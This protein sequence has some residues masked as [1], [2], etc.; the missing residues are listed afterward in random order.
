MLVETI[1]NDIKQSMRDRDEAKTTTLRGLM[2]A[3][4]YEVLNKGQKKDEASD[5][6][7]VTVVSRE[8]KK[9]KEA[10][11]L[12][13]KGERQELADK[14]KAEIDI[15]SLYLPQQLSEDE[16][17]KIVDQVVAE[18]GASS[19]QDMGTVMKAVMERVKGQADGSMVSNLVRAKLS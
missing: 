3:V 2:T 9:R 8:I 12:Y 14:E 17:R 7:V 10:I 19:I 15:L 13:Q 1:T 6:D 16:L 5:E 11:E 4:Q 18:T